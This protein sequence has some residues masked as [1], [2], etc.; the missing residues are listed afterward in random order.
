L[1]RRLL[2]TA[3]AASEIVS[4]EW[5]G[6]QIEMVRGK[7]IVGLIDP[8]STYDDQS[9]H[10]TFHGVFSR[11]TNPTPSLDAALDSAEAIGVEFGRYLGSEDAFLITVPD[12]VTYEQLLDALDD[13][14]DFRYVEPNGIMRAMPVGEVN[15]T[16]PAADEPATRAQE[17]TEPG[18][19]AMSPDSFGKDEVRDGSSTWDAF[20]AGDGDDLLSEPSPD[21]LY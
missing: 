21:A 13:I 15:P 16:A 18:E 6:Q 2:F 3:V 12:G 20:N 4:I 9:G 14:P 1:D 5:G 8:G 17:P 7:W 10:W 11:D 19:F